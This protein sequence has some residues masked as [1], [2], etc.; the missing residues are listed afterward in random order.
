MAQ[1]GFK[2]EK[3]DLLIR[4]G[5]TFG[6]FVVTTLN[7]DGITPVNLTGCTMR[8]QIR[9][10]AKSAV[11]A[12]TLN[13]VITDAPGGVY[14]FELSDAVTASLKAGESEIDD[15]SKYVWD[16]EMVDSLGRVIPVYYGDVTVFREVTKV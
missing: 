10:L 11:A 2:G 8:G 7:P 15:A 12:A 14:Q 4:Q 16:L 3:L 1:I 13:C 9:K 5:A 6:P